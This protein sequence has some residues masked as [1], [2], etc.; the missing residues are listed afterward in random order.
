MRENPHRPARAEIRHYG[1][2]L[3]APIKSKHHL[4]QEAEEVGCTGIIQGSARNLYTHQICEADTSTKADGPFYCALCKTDALL[5]KCTEKIDHFA[6]IARLSPVLGPRETELHRMCKEEICRALSERHPEG[7]WA[8][9]RTIPAN[10]HKRIPELRPDVSG[11]IS[12][13][14][15]AIEVQASTLTPTKII[16]RSVAYAKRGI[17]LLWVVPLREPLGVEP[18]RPR[19]YESYLHSLYFGRTYYWWPGCRHTLVPVHYGSASRHVEYREWFEDGMQQSGGGYDA[20]YK[21]IKTPIHGPGL[22]IDADFG[23]HCRIEFTP[24]NERKKVPSCILW[25]DTYS[26]WWTS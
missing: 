15:I 4:L 13:Q 6:H 22:L 7:N 12:D 23:V 26:Q 11:R 14:R 25:K 24:E 19:L 5:R 3:M 2:P 17:A 16:K 20:E 9:E 10:I 21:I 8:T 18:L 1:Y